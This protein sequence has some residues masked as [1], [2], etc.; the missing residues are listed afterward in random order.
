V[1]VHLT[2]LGAQAA[3]SFLASRGDVLRQ[4]LRHLDDRE[5][6]QLGQ[7]MSKLLTGLYRRPGD[8]E[9]ICR[10]CDRGVC[11]RDGAACPVGEADRDHRV[12]QERDHG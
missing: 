2:G 3:H 7:L 9:R 4:A 10:L 8:G 6:E 11:V 5:Q 12:A 1:R